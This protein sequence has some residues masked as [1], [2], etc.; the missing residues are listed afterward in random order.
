MYEEITLNWP[1]GAQPIPT[2]DVSCEPMT[3]NQWWF[4]LILENIPEKQGTA[5]LV[6]F[7]QC[8]VLF[9][10]KT[11]AKTKKILKKHSC[12]F[13][14]NVVF[15]RSPFLLCHR[16]LEQ[17]RYIVLYCRGEAMIVSLHVTS[18]LRLSPKLW[19]NAAHYT[20]W[21]A[22]NLGRISK[23]GGASVEASARPRTAA[24]LRCGSTRLWQPVDVCLEPKN[25]RADGAGLKFQAAWGNTLT[26]PGSP[27][28]P[29]AHLWSSFRGEYPLWS[30]TPALGI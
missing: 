5:L 17:T 21:A 19:G 26:L 6:G 8:L 9:F 15:S 27:D 3:P 4:T 7:S 14:P 18:G 29:A 20:F 28:I 30:D 11:V 13:S 12:G 2:A 23:T 10:K 1:C 24:C 22:P 16:V 25:I